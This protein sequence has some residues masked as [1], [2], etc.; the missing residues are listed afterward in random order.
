MDGI[1][2]K[3]E[4]FAK[5]ASHLHV[6]NMMNITYPCTLVWLDRSDYLDKTPFVSI[7]G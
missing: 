4:L 2:I 3:L 6:S 5:N 7:R 1:Y